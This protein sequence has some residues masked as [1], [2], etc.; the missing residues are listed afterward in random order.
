MT[1]I[2]AANEVIDHYNSH[3]MKKERTYSIQTKEAVR[4]L[5]AEILL[6]RK[7]RKWSEGELAER[8]G[9]TRYTLQKIQKGDLTVSIGL[10]FEA[11]IIVGLDLFEAEKS[12]LDHRANL[13]LIHGAL[14]P[15]T[16]KRKS[17]K[18]VDD[19]F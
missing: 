18:G 8:I 19:D 6:A 12:R 3:N 5:G 1:V 11:A 14:L 9:I 10:F 15:Q 2:T 4:L 17:T 13:A 16:R 7:Q